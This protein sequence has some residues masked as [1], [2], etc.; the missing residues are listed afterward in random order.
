M[1]QVVRVPD[2]VYERLTT[3]AERADVSRGTIVKEWMKKADRF[4]EMDRGRY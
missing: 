2:P 3:E 1:G 4:D